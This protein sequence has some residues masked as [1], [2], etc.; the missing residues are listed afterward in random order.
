MY[1][2]IDAI[3][4]QNSTPRSSK[5]ID[6]GTLV[7]P[8]LTENTPRKQMLRAMLMKTRK[9]FQKKIKILKQKQRRTAKCFAKLKEVLASLK[10]K[11]LL[12]AQQLDILKDLGKFDKELLFCVCVSTRFM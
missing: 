5:I 11:N 6:Q 7:S 2:A 10:K 8:C 1:I 3:S 12:D 4:Q 9:E